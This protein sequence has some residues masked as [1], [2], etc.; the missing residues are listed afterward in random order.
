[1]T[2]GRLPLPIWPW[3]RRTPSSASTVAGGLQRLALHRQDGWAVALNAARP[4][5]LAGGLPAG[6]ALVGCRLLR[7]DRARPADDPAPGRRPSPPA[8]CGHLRQPDLAI[9]PEGGAHAG[10]DGTKP[11]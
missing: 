1:M 5:E 7:G 9:H 4:A 6:A 8:E 2:N 10:P 3:C 11:K